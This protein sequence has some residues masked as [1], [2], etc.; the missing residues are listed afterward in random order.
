MPVCCSEDFD[1]EFDDLDLNDGGHNTHSNTLSP[2][3]GRMI[4]QKEA[5]QLRR[6]RTGRLALALTNASS[7]RLK[8]W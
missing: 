2:S 3:K 6:Q 8:L 4:T 1:K 5:G 7:S